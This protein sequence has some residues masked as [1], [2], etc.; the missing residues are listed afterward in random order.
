MRSAL[1]FG[2]S[3][4][5]GVPVIE[6]LLADG[7]RVVA[8]SR[9]PQADRERLTWLRGDLQQAQGL[10]GRVDAIFSLGP[11]DHF[12]HWYERT[13]MVAPRVIAF[14]STSVETKQDSAD[15]HER[16]IA[17]R[18]RAAE[19][20]IFAI[21]RERQAKAT[22]LRPTLVYG[23]ARDRSLTEIARMARRVGFFVL[24]RGAD[25]LRQPVHVQDLADA[26]LAVMDADAA[27]GR[28]YALPGGETLAYAQ[29]VE[30]TLASLQPPARLIRMPAPMFK[31]AVAIAH[32]FGKMQGLGDAAVVR[33]HEDLVFDV[34]PAHVDFGYAPRAF[35]PTD[36]M[37]SLSPKG[38]SFVA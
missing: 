26:T 22:L 17:D 34:E 1:V 38:T 31:A 13:A 6:R 12:S 11:L 10:P 9:T 8:V 29:M 15:A 16:D 19:S 35:N 7:W 20:R 24:P 4:Q 3:G 36:A 37:F 28:S 2:G 14:G 30:R 25:G 5:I 27:S 23:A 33:M 32:M 18:L 21:A